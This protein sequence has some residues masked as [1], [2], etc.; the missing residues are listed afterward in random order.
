MR[1]VAKL[2]VL[3]AGALLLVL[4]VFG[5]ISMDLYLPALPAL[6]VDLGA[7]TST[8]Q[9]TVTACLL[10]LAGGQLIAGLQRDVPRFQRVVEIDLDFAIVAD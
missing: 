8:A 6:T 9:L 4:T 3:G 2:A 5:P 1:R 10:G 7:A